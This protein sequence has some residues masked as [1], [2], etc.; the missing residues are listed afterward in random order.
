MKTASF[1]LTLISDGNIWLDGGAMFG[2]VPKPLWSRI[3]EHDDNNRVPLDTTSLLIESDEA[4]ILV[5]TGIG[6]HYS[7]KQHQIYKFNFQRRLLDG[8]AKKGVS[9]ESIDYVVQSHLHFD[10]C[11]SLLSG[12]G[13]G[14]Y[15]LNFPNAE[16]VVQRGEWEAAMN[17][18]VRSKPSYFENAFYETLEKEGT[19]RLVEGIDEIIPGVKVSQRGGHTEHHQIVEIDDGDDR[20]IFVGDF[21]PMT[22]HINIA[23]SMGFDVLPIKTSEDKVDFLPRAAD[24]GWTIVFVHD[25]DTPAA[26]IKK[27]GK[28]WAAEPV[29][30]F[31]WLNA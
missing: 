14:G 5:E 23:Y 15:E 3:I 4:T 19:V 12:D 13:S 7:E 28:K 29:E 20:I 30:D 24:E 2:V 25:P 16:V 27:D 22:R 10:H 17:P 26:R 18:D 1:D 9:P 6:D 8:L 31:G 21:I 11:G